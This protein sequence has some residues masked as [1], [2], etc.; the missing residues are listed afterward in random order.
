LIDDDLAGGKFISQIFA[1]RTRDTFGGGVFPDFQDPLIPPFGTLFDQSQNRSRKYGAKLS[2]ERPIP[3]FEDLT[4]TLGFDAL[5]DRT[6]QV[7]IATDR[8]WVPQTDFRSLAP[9]GQFNLALFD[10]KLRLAGGIRSENVQIKIPDFTTLAFYGRRSVDGGSPKFSDLL[11]NGGAIFEP[12][13]GIRFYASYAE[14][15]TV[16]DVGRITR[17][18][19]I[20]NVDIDTYLD[21][22]PIISNNREVGVEVKKGPLDA[23][24]SYFWSTSTKGQLLVLINNVFEVQRQRVEI[25]GLELNLA[26]AM[27]IKGLKLSAGY[28]HLLGKSD[29]NGDDIVDIDLDGANISPDRF[30]LAASY[31]SGDFSARLQTQFYLSRNFRGADPRN[32]FEGYTLT[33]AYIRYQTALGGLSASVSNLFDKQYI[34]YNSDTNRPTDNARFFAGRGRTFSLA[35]DY[36]F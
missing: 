20:P 23:S 5:Y 4:A 6:I 10:K 2:Y 25:E 13:D 28:A 29:S 35:W 9:F 14:G 22:S 27:P 11:I 12:V 1:S 32:G 16:P 30:N 36:R 34:S 26:V 21:I 18:I 33:D 3:G 8:P 17:A 15:Y 31:A 7:L 19:N 24:A